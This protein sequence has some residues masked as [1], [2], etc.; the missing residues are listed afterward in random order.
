MTLQEFFAALGPAGLGLSGGVDSALL[1]AAACRY[2]A[3]VRPYFVKTAFQ[4]AFERED[5]QKVADLCGVPLTVI[6]LDV[7][8]LERVAENPADRCYHCKNAIFSALAQR[9]AA[10]GRTVLLDGTNASDD[11][12]DRP[13]M[14]ALREMGVRSPL[15]ECGLDKTAVRRMAK[16][17]GLPVWDKPAYAC[18]ATRVPTGQRLEGAQLRRIEQAEG[19]LFG[20][21]FSDFR[22]RVMGNTARLQLPECQLP[23]A[24]D[25][26][27][28][29]TA[30]LGALFDGVLLDLRA[31]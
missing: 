28:E 15:R 11:A 23:Q 10:D 13:G 7:L 6:E 14:R 27:E 29:I 25:R 16:Q 24:F 31:R 12:S 17:L 3:D 4:P 18:L 5:A 26:R 20:M 22:V 19:T 2:G 1:L 30:A 21:G 9:A 8:A